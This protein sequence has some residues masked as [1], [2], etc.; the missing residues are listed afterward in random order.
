M[1]L[2]AHNLPL[3]LGPFPDKAD[4]SCIISPRLIIKSVMVFPGI[5]EN[6]IGKEVFLDA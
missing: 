3:H 6:R 2:S 5:F 4:W 1:G